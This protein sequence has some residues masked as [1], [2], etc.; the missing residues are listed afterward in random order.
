MSIGSSCSLA[1]EQVWL[2]RHQYILGQ[3]IALDET[4]EFNRSQ[5]IK[6]SRILCEEMCIYN[7]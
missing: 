5:I 7:M 1:S 6:E 2:M 3:K 4:E